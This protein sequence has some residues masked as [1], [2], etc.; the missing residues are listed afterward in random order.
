M[1]PNEVREFLQ[2]R[3]RASM[4][5]LRFSLLWKINMKTPS[6]TFI[7]ELTKLKSDLKEAM[8]RYV[9]KEN[10]EA[11]K[12]LAEEIIHLVEGQIQVLANAAVKLNSHDPVRLRNALGEFAKLLPEQENQKLFC[13]YESMVDLLIEES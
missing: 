5:G 4:H 10:F 6:S 13:S 11:A 3:C 1:R 9:P 2:P 8:S 7:R 12:K